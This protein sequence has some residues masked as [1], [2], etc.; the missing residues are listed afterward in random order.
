LEFRQLIS[1]VSTLENPTTHPNHISNSSPIAIQPLLPLPNST[2]T[3]FHFI[4]K[5]LCMNFLTICSVWSV[6]SYIASALLCD[7]FSA[8]RTKKEFRFRPSTMEC[9]TVTMEKMNEEHLHSVPSD[10]FS[11]QKMRTDKCRFQG[12]KLAMEF[13]TVATVPMKF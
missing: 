7:S 9:A 12:A 3:S 13:A 10:D 8:E 5:K 4:A 6:A 1:S 11:V 2:T